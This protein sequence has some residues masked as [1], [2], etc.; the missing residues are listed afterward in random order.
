V[1]FNP[2]FATC[3]ERLVELFYREIALAIAKPSSGE[4]VAAA[5]KRLRKLAAYL[6]VCGTA[7][8]WALEVLSLFLPGAGLFAKLAKGVA[9]IGEVAKKGAE[10]EREV[11][12]G[13]RKSQPQASNALSR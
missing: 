1:E 6:S 2:W 8:H 10:S 9:G 12:V 5:E 4:N 3:Y 13:S 7:A 11:S